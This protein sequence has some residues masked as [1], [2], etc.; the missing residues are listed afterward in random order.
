[1]RMLIVAFFSLFATLPAWGQVRGIEITEHGIYTADVQSST[2]D[3]QGVQQNIST[4]FRLAAGTDKIPVRPG[5]RFGLLYKVV[6]SPGGGTVSLKK[7]VVYPPGGLNS[8][9]KPQPIT[10]SE[11]TLSPKIGEIA[12]TGYRLDDPWEL[13]RGLWTIEL[14]YNDR[15]L[16]EQRFT[17]VAP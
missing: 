8:P 7:V 12:Y 15:K 5:V 17:L 1:M 13:V 14:W 4:N 9:A 3:S 6:G 10:R 2:R 16:A 11:T